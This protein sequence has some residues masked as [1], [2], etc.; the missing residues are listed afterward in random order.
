VTREQVQAEGGWDGQWPVNLLHCGG[1]LYTKSK[2]ANLHVRRHSKKM[3]ILEIGLII[4]AGFTGDKICHYF[5]KRSGS[6]QVE[7]EIAT[8]KRHP[9]AQL[10]RE[11]EWTDTWR[12]RGLFTALIL[13]IV[14]RLILGFSSVDWPF[15]WT[16]IFFIVASVVGVGVGYLI[17]KKSDQ[18]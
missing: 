18:F 4:V 9:D 14:T 8:I 11:N 5:Y 6:Y 3:W 16:I 13:L 12:S 2:S 1:Q 15:P 17:D 10:R 7:S